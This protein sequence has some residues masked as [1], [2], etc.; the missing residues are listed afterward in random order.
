M[1][2][3]PCP[4]CGLRN[5]NEFICGGEAQRKRPADPDRETDEAWADYLYNNAN[6]K[7]V[8]TEWWWH[9]SG[10]TLWFKIDRNT[11]THEI[12]PI[13]ELPE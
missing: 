3:I 13:E 7:G 4:W 10:C 6:P 9:V 1:L 5:E 2:E 11:L 8:V 12:T